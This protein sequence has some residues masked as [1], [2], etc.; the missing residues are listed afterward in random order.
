MPTPPPIRNLVPMLHV[1][2]VER[3]AAFYSRLG[4]SVAHTH[5]E[6]DVE[7]E[8]VWAWLRSSG[9][10]DLML[11]RVDEPA[12]PAHQ[13]EL[14]HLYCDDVSEMHAQLRAAG[15]AVDEIVTPFYCPIGEFRTMDPDGH[16]LMITSA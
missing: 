12:H 8:T 7:G 4:F 1:V 14:L 5:C 10:V 15:V 11:A 16:G 13:G 3:A 6:P 9:G 2:D